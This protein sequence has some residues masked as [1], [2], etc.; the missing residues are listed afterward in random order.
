MMYNFDKK[1]DRSKN[2]SAKWEEI[3]QNFGDNNLLPMWVADMDFE[4][5]PEILESMKEKL[6]QKIFGYV[7]R[8]DSYFESAANWTKKRYGYDIDPKT[9]VHSPG[10]IPTISLAVKLFTSENDKIMINETAAPALGFESAEHAV[11]KKVTNAFEAKRFG[12]D[13][14]EYEVIGV[15]KDYHHLS[16]HQAI[17]PMICLPSVK[18]LP[19]IRLMPYVSKKY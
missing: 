12:G 10:V 15:I 17:D 18:V 4:T 7:S 5:A 9:L 1:V 8:T 16:L 13:V 11:G 3:G 19:S 2:N 14:F 6:D